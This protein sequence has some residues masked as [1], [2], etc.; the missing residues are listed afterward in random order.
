MNGGALDEYRLFARTVELGGLTHAARALGLTPSAASRSLQRLEDRLGTRLLYRTTRKVTPTEEGVRLH[1]RILRLLEDLE[2][3][4]AEARGRA[5]TPSGTLRVSMLT[6]F[7]IHLML[8]LMPEFRARHPDVRLHLDFTDRRIDLVAEGIDVAIRL[9]ELD[10]SRLV[11]RKLAWTTRLVVAAPSYLAR[12]GT[13]RTPD[14]LRDHDCLVFGDSVLVHLNRWPF[15][16]P[17]GRREIDISGPFTIGE[18]ETQY[19]MVEA[20][21]GI[22]RLSRFVTDRALRDGRLVPLLQDWAVD[23]EIGIHAVYPHRRHLPTRVSCFVDFL[24]ERFGPVP[25]WE[26]PG[27][28]PSGPGRAGP[29]PVAGFEG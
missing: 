1:R 21:L 19:R 3:A 4:E 8:P 25:P 5:E 27:H 10:D 11:A 18:G 22:A 14:D 12:R 15:A 13:P 23:E 28:S 24:A 20:G 7:G 29:G 6:A 9:G 2:E 16:T 17:A 26:V